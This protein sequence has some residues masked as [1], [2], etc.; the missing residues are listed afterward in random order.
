MPD[1]G[2]NEKLCFSAFCNPFRGIFDA[3]SPPNLADR[4]DR[5][6]AGGLCPG[7]AQ[8]CGAQACGGR[9]SVCR[10]KSVLHGE[11]AAV[12]GAAVR[13]DQGQRLSAGPRGRHEA[14]D[15]RGRED[16]G[17]KRRAKFRQHDRRDGAHGCAADTHDQG[18][19]G[20]HRGEHERDAAGGAAR[21]SA[22]I[23]RASRRDLPEP[24]AVCAREVAL[25]AA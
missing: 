20:A 15:H 5:L 23:R 24:Q 21:G 12:P 11:R 6:R 25:H 3:A 4:I 16:R 13:Q 18:V 8:G 10:G 2:R 1:G 14:A 19:L 9:C 17:P 7:H 22:E